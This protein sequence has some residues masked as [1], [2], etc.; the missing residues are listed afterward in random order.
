MGRL[1]NWDVYLES[2]K[3]AAYHW[4]LY[5]GLMVEWLMGPLKHWADYL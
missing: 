5:S 1:K 4:G 2:F 3:M